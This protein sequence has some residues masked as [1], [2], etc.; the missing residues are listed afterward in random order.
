MVFVVIN[1]RRFLR[2]Y[3]I[4]LSLLI[5]LTLIKIIKIRAGTKQCKN[6]KNFTLKILLFDTGIFIF[7]IFDYSVYTFMKNLILFILILFE[8]LKKSVYFSYSFQILLLQNV[9]YDMKAFE[10]NATYVHT[11][12]G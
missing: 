7:F 1:H 8:Q 12:A 9:I 3:I 2:N 6:S 10:K 11:H 5:S 4:F